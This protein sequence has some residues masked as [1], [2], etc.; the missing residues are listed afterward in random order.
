[1]WR[2]WAIG[3][4]AMMMLFW[5]SLSSVPSSACAG[6][7]AKAS[8]RPDTALEILRQRYVRSEIYKYEFAAKK[9]NLGG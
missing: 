6:S 4:M 7:S 2:D 9:K 5:R 8:G 1:M 3:M